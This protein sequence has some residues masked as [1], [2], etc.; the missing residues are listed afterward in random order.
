[1]SETIDFLNLS[2][3]LA[4]C[5]PNNPHFLRIQ[6]TWCEQKLWDDVLGTVGPDFLYHL[7]TA[8]RIVVHDV[9]EKR[10]VPR[11]LWQGLPWVI[12]ACERVW[13]LDARPIHSRS[14][15]NVTRYFLEAFATLDHR[16][17]RQVAYFGKY[18]GDEHAEVGVCDWPT[19]TGTIWGAV[20]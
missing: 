9:S 10:R 6:S 12:Y 2:N 15:M 18:V 16:L 7:A 3:G 8:D 13:G 5:Q 20:A 19:R 17:V 11:A 14:G 1:M 4:C